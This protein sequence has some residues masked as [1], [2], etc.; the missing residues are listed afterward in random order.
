MEQQSR[1][2]R[3]LRHAHLAG[4]SPL[5]FGGGSAVELILENYEF[6]RIS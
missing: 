1:A 5:A 6:S 4:R 3:R 2:P